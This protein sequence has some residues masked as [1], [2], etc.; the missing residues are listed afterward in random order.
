VRQVTF[1]DLA[2]LVVADYKANGKKTL[3][4]AERRL[5]LHL[6]PYFGGRLARTS[7]PPTCG[8]SS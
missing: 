2:E 5:R 1:D 3:K 7:P 8:S 4:W 6:A